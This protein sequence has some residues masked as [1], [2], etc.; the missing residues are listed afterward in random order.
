MFI[1]LI[2]LAVLRAAPFC[3]ILHLFQLR[4]T[5]AHIPVVSK[6]SG[7]PARSAYLSILS[8]F[9]MQAVACLS[10]YFSLSCAPYEMVLGERGRH[11]PLVGKV[12][13]RSSS[14][15]KAIY[16]KMIDYRMGMSKICLF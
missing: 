10:I 4:C 6:I 5:R 14:H 1:V 3:V 9:E 13:L 7:S 15:L 8:L 2:P 12:R 16:R 11:T